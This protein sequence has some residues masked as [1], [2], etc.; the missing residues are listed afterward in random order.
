VAHICRT[1]PTK[2]RGIRV[3][4]KIKYLLLEYS[5]KNKNCLQ[6]K[7][8]RKNTLNIYAQLT[9]ADSLFKN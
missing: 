6:G 7:S 2:G 3:S 1:N 5:T 8:N 9:V 4:E